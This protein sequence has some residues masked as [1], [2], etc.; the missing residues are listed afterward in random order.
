MSFSA[1]GAIL[2]KAEKENK[3]QGEQTE[4]LSVSSQ[5]YKLFYY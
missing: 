2:K 5:A 1:I 4:K 3:A